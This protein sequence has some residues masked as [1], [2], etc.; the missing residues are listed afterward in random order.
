MKRWFVVGRLLM[1]LVVFIMLDVACAKVDAPE[2]VG[3][4]RIVNAVA[5]FHKYKTGLIVI[6]FGT[7]VT[8]DCVSKKGEYLGGLIMPGIELSIQS[9]YEKTAL[10]PKITLRPTKNLI[11]RSTE[12]SMRAGILFGLGAACDGLITKYSKILGRPLL[13][14]ATGGSSAP[15]SGTPTLER[16]IT[17]VRI[18]S[19]S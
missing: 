1:V 15:L 11:G 12:E 2:K 5:A 3:Q 18:P 13:V 16:T 8:F 10:L 19:L 7:A 9:L 14:I 6:D 17:C 4:D